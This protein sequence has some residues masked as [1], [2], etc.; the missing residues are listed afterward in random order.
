MYFLKDLKNRFDFFLRSNIT[1]SRKGYK[2]NPY[3]I[4]SINFSNEQA[5]VYFELKE[6]YNL[7]FFGSLNTRNFLENLYF[8]NIFDKY[9]SKPS[10]SANILD[11]GS[12]NWSYARSQYLFFNSYNNIKNL[13]GIELDSYRL[14][15]NLYTRYETAKFYIKDLPNTNYISGDFLEHNKNYDYIIWIL[16]FITKYPLYKWGLPLRYFKPKEMLIHAY[17]LLNKNGEM[18]II[19]QGIKEAEIQNG[20]LKALNIPIDLS[21]EKIKDDFELF[22]NERYCFKIVKNIRD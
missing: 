14:C 8:L 2:E 19:N 3:D 7:S 5:K 16:P 22:E 10:S 21:S 12:K 13:N 17:N 15:S 9:L 11:I 6:K 20:L 18:L 4:N 1:L